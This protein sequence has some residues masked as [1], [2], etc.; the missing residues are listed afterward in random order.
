MTRKALGRGIKALIPD[1]KA[2]EQNSLL[3][4]EIG[5]VKP[6]RYQPRQKFDAAKHLGLVR[7]I[8]SQG[9]LQPVVVQPSAG[10][11]YEL[12]TGE[13]RWRAAKEAGLQKIPALVR[14]AAAP[15]SLEMALIEN[16]QRE[17]LNPIEA[18]HGYQRLIDEFGLTQEKVSA[19]VG[20]ERSSIANHIR[21]LKLPS[22]IQ[23][24]VSEGR[25]SMGHARCLLSLTGREKQL[26]A[27]KIILSR[28]LSV[29]EAERLVK[30]LS[31]PPPGPS[32]QKPTRDVH[33][34]HLESTLRRAL[35]TKVA[36][37]PSGQ[38]GKIEIHYFTGD[39][40]DRL[41]EHLLRKE[42]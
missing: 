7:S 34:A 8:E 32:G 13:R 33:L 11:T 23:E 12:I 42:A 26:Q 27:R 17:D 29:R 5:D 40:L 4:L 22:E 30:R 6:G 18:A 25:L 19:R 31:Q 24:D 15:E 1:R 21:L 35:G 20:K 3:Q 14:S 36:I 9:L 28:T 16:I 2:A 41:S 39:E 38:G 37:R 10:G